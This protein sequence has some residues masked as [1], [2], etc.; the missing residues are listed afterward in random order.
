MFLLIGFFWFHGGQGGQ[1]AELIVFITVLNRL[2][3]RVSSVGQ[4]KSDINRRL[5]MIEVVN[6]VLWTEGKSLAPGW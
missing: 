1:L 5:G 6:E 4:L 2:A 3:G